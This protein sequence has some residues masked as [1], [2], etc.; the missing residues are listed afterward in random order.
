MAIE[1]RLDGVAGADRGVARHVAISLQ[2]LKQHTHD[3]E[4]SKLVDEI[5][6]GRAQLRDVVGSD[7]FR[8]TLNPLVEQFASHYREL[9]ENEIAELA[10]EGERRLARL[11]NSGLPPEGHSSEDDQDDSRPVT[12]ILSSDW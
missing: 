11:R 7:A 6:A 4:F 10:A 3:A 8:Q 1:D 12:R 2:V 9:D 5:L